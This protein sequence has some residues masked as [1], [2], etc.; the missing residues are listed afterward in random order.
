MLTGMQ[1]CKPCWR[2]HRSTLTCGMQQGRLRCRPT[3]P[4]D[5]TNPHL[6][7][8]GS[9]GRPGCGGAE[10]IP[11]PLTFFGLQGAV[12]G[13]Q[14]Q[15]LTQLKLKQ[16]RPHVLIDF[17]IV[18]D[19]GEELACDGKAAGNLQVCGGESG[20]GL[21]DGPAVGIQARL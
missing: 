4:H 14:G 3:R 12:A 19:S 17:R 20:W 18:S 11:H 8:R 15:A 7:S 2:Y 5:H 16:G 13:L 9:G 10:P 6:G 21:E 1:A